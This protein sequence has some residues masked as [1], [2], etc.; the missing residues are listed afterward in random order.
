MKI[1][2]GLLALTLF[3]PIMSFIPVQKTIVVIDVGHGGKDPGNL[4]AEIAE[5]DLCLAV[6]KKIKEMG[7]NSAL[8]I[9]LTRDSDKFLS[10]QDRVDLINALNPD[11]LISLHVN[12]S[13]N[14]TDQGVEF[15]ICSETSQKA[16]SAEFALKVKNNLEKVVPV[17]EIVKANLYVLKNTRCPGTLIEMGFLSNPRDKDFI[18][19][20]IGQTH[21]AVALFASI[22]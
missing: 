11:Y 3:A 22:K 13:E 16:A 21:L 6:A 5:K 8:D 18:L 7:T 10:L 20:E 19:S 12:L 9:T 4:V 17:K 2:I 1:L 15:F 14:T